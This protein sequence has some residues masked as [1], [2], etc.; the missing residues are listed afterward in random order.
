MMKT[1]LCI[2]ILTPIKED[3]IEINAYYFISPQ[4]IAGTHSIIVGKTYSS[5]LQANGRI[6]TVLRLHSAL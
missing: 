6:F 3:Y 2:Q 5:L 4:H 1:N